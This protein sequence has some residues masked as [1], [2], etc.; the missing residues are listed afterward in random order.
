M[1]PCL[2]SVAEYDLKHML[3]G[4]A[5]DEE[6]ERSVRKA[7]WQKFEGVASLMENKVEVRHVRPMHTIGG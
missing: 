6:I 5:T 7:F 4:G 1:V 2:F 3:R